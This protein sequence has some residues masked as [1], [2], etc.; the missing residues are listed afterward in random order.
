MA[1]G[2]RDLTG[3][4]LGP[5]RLEA[6]L[7]DGALGRAYR[8]RHVVL[9]VLRVIKVVQADSGHDPQSRERFLREARAAARLDH[10]N[11]VPVHDF[12]SEAD[13]QYLVMEYVESAT[14]AEHLSSLPARGRLDAPV[15][16]QWVRDV[17][18]ALDYAH[19]FLIVHQA[20]EPGR[21]L[22]RSEGGRAM[23][24]GFGFA[25]AHTDPTPTAS[26]RPLSTCAYLSPEQCDGR[27]RLTT[28]CDIYALAVMLYEIATGEPPF[29]RDIS[30][31]S[32][33]LEKPMPRLTTRGLPRALEAALAKGLA[34]SPGDR[35]RTARELA[36]VCLEAV[37]ER[38]EAPAEPDGTVGPA[39]GAAWTPPLRPVPVGPVEP[40]EPPPRPRLRLPDVRVLAA[41]AAVLVGV[42]GLAV[43][44]RS[45]QPPAAPAAPVAVV[46]PP[47]PAHGA[48]GKPVQVA[49]LRLTVLGVDAG[50]TPPRSLK[51]PAGSGF[52]AVRVRY[53]GGDGTAIVSP[54]DW[55][56]TDASGAVHG[57]VVQDLGGAL[58][59]REL[60]SGE[61]VAGIIG[62]VVP[63]AAQGLV[64]TFAAELGDQSAQIPLP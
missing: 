53:Q 11:I 30:A 8:A 13:L 18:A 10:P 40:V 39:P 26:G 61:T 23:L 22:I 3:Q 17:A 43:V 38:T 15:V 16:R 27:S 60:R 57:A 48:V 52:V 37:P 42:G 59:E 32:G 47:P 5:Y 21:V 62:F 64:L 33:H 14:L 34:K 24:T 49:G 6:M 36:G 1:I 45:L 7:G 50:A 41:V 12:G 35:Q 4:Q 29:G 25:H 63:P 31:V 51:V 9:D 55:A 20:L 58:P 56:L 2:G 44:A 19:S 54:Y 46:S 28:A